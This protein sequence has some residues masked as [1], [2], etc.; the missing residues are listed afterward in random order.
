M[1]NV[2]V[3]AL[4]VVAAVSG[5]AGAGGWWGI[6]SVNHGGIMTDVNVPVNYDPA[7]FKFE[8]PAFEVVNANV[9]A[10]GTASSILGW[11][12]SGD[13]SFGKLIGE[14]KGEGAD[15][16]INIYCDAKY[17]NILGIIADVSY[18][19]HGTAIKFK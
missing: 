4:F 16:V 15:T 13:T 9:S 6:N 10:T 14:A 1:R 7:N 18:T 17:N 3:L 5:C 2:L 8:G 12:N 11:I 19:L